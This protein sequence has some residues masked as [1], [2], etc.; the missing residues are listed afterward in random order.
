MRALRIIDHVAFEAPAGLEDATRYAFGDDGPGPTEGATSDASLPASVPAGLPSS[1]VVELEA[2]AGRATPAPEVIAE[3][4]ES[5]TTVFPFGTILDEGQT[6]LDGRRAW[7]LAYEVGPQGERTVG[8]VTVANLPD[9]DF[10]KLSMRVAEL[11]ELGPRFGPTLASVSL[12]GGQA[13]TPAGPGHRRERVGPIAL[14]VPSDL[15]GPR[16]GLYVD[17]DDRLR[18]RIAV[19]PVGAD[20]VMLDDAIAADA[21]AGTLLDREDRSWSWGWW[22]RH[23]LRGVDPPH[24][25][26]AVVRAGL[27]VT[28]PAATDDATPTRVRQVEI[29]GTAE[30][31]RA[32]ALHAAFD[33]LLASV[34]WHGG[35]GA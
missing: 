6:L 32:P 23:R 11:A 10:V 34:R 16:S 26:R 18:L 19:R 31:S 22:V 13:P 12:R 21:K 7:F 35:E 25:E 33:A 8:M 9:G 17:A 5:I 27:T 1:L 3:L 4:R 28:D 24:R 29:H 20:P 14:D 30:G 2:P 15:P